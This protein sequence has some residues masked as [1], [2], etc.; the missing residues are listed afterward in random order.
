MLTL[1]IVLT[2]QTVNLISVTEGKM[3]EPDFNSAKNFN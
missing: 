3:R 2:T 1:E